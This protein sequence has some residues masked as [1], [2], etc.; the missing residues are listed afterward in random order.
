M[1]FTPHLPR[2][3]LESIETYLTKDAN[4]SIKQSLCW[5]RR[6]VVCRLDLLS[7]LNQCGDSEVYFISHTLQY[8]Y[9]SGKNIRNSSLTW[10]S[11]FAVALSLISCK[12]NEG[13]GLAESVK[14]CQSF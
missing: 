9:V 2:S 12:R 6:V 13:V 14:Q 5:L 8:R 7:A 4:L 3:Y 11:L 10:L 1:S